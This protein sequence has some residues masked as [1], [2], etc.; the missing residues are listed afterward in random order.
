[1]EE[2]KIFQRKVLLKQNARYIE[3]SRKSS[4]LGSSS[5]CLQERSHEKGKN[6]RDINE[7]TQQLASCKIY[8][9][10]VRGARRL[11]N[12]R[13]SVSNSILVYTVKPT[14]YYPLFKHNALHHLNSN[15]YDILHLFVTISFYHLKPWYSK[16]G[17]YTRRI[18]II[19][20]LVRNAETEVPPQMY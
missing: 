12:G 18:K 4:L 17:S 2:N 19:Q 13:N 14:Q 11:K 3:G 20:Q 9:K 5:N 15:C 10:K 1:M 6:L 7:Y 8:K 16:C